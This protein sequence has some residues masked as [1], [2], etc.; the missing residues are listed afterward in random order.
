MAKSGPK[1]TPTKILQIRGS[2]RAD[3]RRGEP[4]PPTPKS[5]P[6]PEWLTDE[7]KVVWKSVIAL[8]KPL[9]LVTKVD[10]NAL[11]RYATLFVEWKKAAAFVQQHGQ[12]FS[13]PTADG[14]H[15]NVKLLPHMRLVVGMSTELHRLEHDF[16][17]T[18]SARASFGMELDKYG[19]QLEVNRQTEN[20]NR[21]FS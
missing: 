11:G 8:L 5:M 9:G 13:T 7:A 6:A 1:P 2:W 3:R 4:K 14:Q 20:K 10:T 17:M 15:V 12:T 18:P 21:F 19:D 16:G